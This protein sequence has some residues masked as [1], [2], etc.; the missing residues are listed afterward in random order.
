[1]HVKVND[2]E[3]NYEVSGVGNPLLLLHGNG[4]NLHIFDKIS[5]CLSSDFTV[6]A[7]DSRNH[8][9]STFTDNYSYNTLADDIYQFIQVLGL[10]Q[11]S[12]IG[13][14][15]GAIISTILAITYPDLFHKLVLL[16]VN[17]SPNDFKPLVY[18]QLEEAYR[19]SK[20]PLIL[21]MLKEPNIKL[22]ELRNIKSPTLVIA[23]ENDL[24]IPDSFE[25][26]HEA[27]PNSHLKIIPK[28][29]HSSYIIDQDLLY[30]DLKSFL[31]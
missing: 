23:A 26:I 29:D 25:Q 3:L 24:F 12:V 10:T 18:K 11:I 20:D 19:Y 14:S 21:M 7:I 27:I 16:G 30:D 4:E 28:H 15:D 6:Y 13:F 2:I 8:G 5:A 31:L 17:L 9:L 22:E 1:M